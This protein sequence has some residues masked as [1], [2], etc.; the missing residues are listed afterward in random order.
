MNCNTDNQLKRTTTDALFHPIS[1][2]AKKWEIASD[3]TIN[4]ISTDIF[5]E[6]AAYLT[7]EEIH[8]LKF[9]CKKWH[10]LSLQSFK[11]SNMCL[12]K[13]YQ[14]IL[15]SRFDKKIKTPYQGLIFE[16]DLFRFISFHELLEMNE[17]KILDDTELNPLAFVSKIFCAKLN[18]HVEISEEEVF[19]EFPLKLSTAS[20]NAIFSPLIKNGFSGIALDIMGFCTKAPFIDEQKINI[21]RGNFR[22]HSQFYR[23]ISLLI[24]QIGFSKTVKLIT[25]LPEILA[26]IQDKGVLNVSA[27]TQEKISN[28]QGH[29]FLWLL[30]TLRPSNIDENSFK[31]WAS[32]MTNLYAELKNS[33]LVTTVIA[34]IFLSES[35]EMVT[36]YCKKNPEKILDPIDVEFEWSKEK[37]SYTSL[38][39]GLFLYKYFFPYHKKET[40]K[41]D[42]F[43]IRLRNIS[44][45]LNAINKDDRVAIIR[46]IC[47]RLHSSPFNVLFHSKKCLAYMLKLLESFLFLEE[48]TDIQG[49]ISIVL[50]E[51]ASKKCL[52]DVFEKNKSSCWKDLKIAPKFFEES[53]NNI[54]T[55][56]PELFFKAIDKEILIYPENYQKL[57]SSIIEEKSRCHRLSFMKSFILL[58]LLPSRKREFALSALEEAMSGP[59][60]G[61][62][63]EEDLGREDLTRTIPF[64]FNV[65][66]DSDIND[67]FGDF[68]Q[69]EIVLSQSPPED[70]FEEE[71]LIKTLSYTSSTEEDSDIS[72]G[73]EEMKFL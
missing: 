28:L 57:Y 44:T 65:E 43:L 31:D 51:I 45:I 50:E 9:V 18:L 19:V 22:S 47:D 27:E 52:L 40:I 37:T 29:Y 72:D 64:Y 36:M 54:L 71:D 21:T 1:K 10:D 39:C 20:L 46:N 5:N 49:H 17:K 23:F 66:E 16:K 35:T 12:L 24:Q 32:K 42:K 11:E 30:K 53:I 62:F 48:H 38:R 61:D 25:G 13:E 8:D 69:K 41:Q 73:D 59:Y 60:Q 70:P 63:K 56:K 67:E 4:W 58:F 14:A 26:G 6:I 34:S 55:I 68:E 15:P 7:S 3:N 33:G 2:K